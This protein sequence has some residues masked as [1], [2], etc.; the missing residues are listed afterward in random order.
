MNAEKKAVNDYL[1]SFVSPERRARMESVLCF[2][3]RYMSVVLEDIFQP[4]NASAVL[5]SC[6]ALGVQDL[7]IIENRNSYRIN[8][9]VELGTAQWLSIRRYNEEENNSTRALQGLKKAGYRLVAAMPGEDHPLEELDLSAGPMAL[10]FGTELSGLSQEAR[11]MADEGF[12]IPMYGFVESFNISV[13]VAITLYSLVS[14]LR[15]SDID[16]RLS[17][18]EREEIR[19]Q[20]LRSSIKQASLL[21]KEFHRGR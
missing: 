3:Q 16:W 21:E 2:R 17:E 7:H 20:W 6:D 15:S 8:P 11:E 12:S 13:A 1:M 14:R 5:R 19:G 10:I 18:E 9:E 4:H